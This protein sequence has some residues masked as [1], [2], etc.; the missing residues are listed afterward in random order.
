[1]RLR[2]AVFFLL[3]SSFI[4]ALKK[5]NANPLFPYIIED[6]K[7]HLRSHSESHLSF[8]AFCGKYNV[9]IASVCQWMRRH[10]LDIST[11]RYEVLLE[12]CHTDP[13]QVLSTIYRETRYTI[14]DT[15]SKERKTPPSSNDIP[16]ENRIKGATITF[17]DGIIVNIQQ[18]TPF[19]LT[20]FIESYNKLTD[21]YHVQPE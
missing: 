19:A 10:G 3:P 7:N 5:M 17:P 21:R 20:K 18:T 15:S 2:D 11:L 8:H 1:K 4:F 14:P 6:Y 9:R 12:N 13:D 16:V